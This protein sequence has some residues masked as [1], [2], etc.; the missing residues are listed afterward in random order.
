MPLRRD[1]VM[2]NIETKNEAAKGASSPT[3]D[4]IDHPNDSMQ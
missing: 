3:V 4:I 1:V 2:L